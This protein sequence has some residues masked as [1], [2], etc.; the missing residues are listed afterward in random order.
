MPK[1]PFAPSTSLWIREHLMREL[2]SYPRKIYLDL[3]ARAER[4]GYVPPS[5]QSIR[6]MI[7]VLHRL[8]L[9]RRVRRE[10]PTR[11]IKRYK[12]ELPRA[13]RRLVWLPDWARLSWYEITPGRENDPRWISPIKALYYPSEWERVRAL[14]PP[15]A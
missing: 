14:H 1:S 10:Y 3:K 8:G 2:E 7:Y 12:P 4:L 6:N 5:Y 13:E 9:I 11:V 15:L